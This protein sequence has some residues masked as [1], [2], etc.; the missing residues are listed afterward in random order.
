[1][2]FKMKFFEI[3]ESNFIS[4]IASVPSSCAILLYAACVGGHLD[5]VQRW[6]DD[7]RNINQS[8]PMLGCHPVTA[9][10]GAAQSQFANLQ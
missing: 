5:M 1:M 6:L 2:N 8:L 10:M 3:N 9:V 4:D 7:D